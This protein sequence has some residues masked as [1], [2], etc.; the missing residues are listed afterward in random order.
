MKRAAADGG[1]TGVGIG[2][3]EDQRA[4]AEHRNTGAAVV[5]DRHIDRHRPGVE[6]VEIDDSARGH[7]GEACPGGAAGDLPGVRADAAEVPR[8]VA[9]NRSRIQRQHATGSGG[10]HGDAVG[11]LR[12]RDRPG[13]ELPAGE[14]LPRVVVDPV[15]GGRGRPAGRQEHGRGQP[16]HV[17]GGVDR[18]QA[19]AARIGHGETRS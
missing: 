3:G 12:S 7:R 8:V 10:V 13:V 19:E 2:C 11:R 4:G 9:E 6:V 5:Q 16:D 15:V 18:G 1:P 17:V 14:L